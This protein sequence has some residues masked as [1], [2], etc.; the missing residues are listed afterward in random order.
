MIKQRTLAEHFQLYVRGYTDG[1]VC[2]NRK[3]QDEPD[4]QIGYDDGRADREKR[5]KEY[6][7]FLDYNPTILRSA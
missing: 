7:K 2:R 3:H 5:L 6:A 4:Y 1:A